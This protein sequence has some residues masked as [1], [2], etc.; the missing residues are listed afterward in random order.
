MPVFHVGGELILEDQYI[1]AKVLLSMVTF[2]AVVGCSNRS[3]RESSK[4]FFHLPAIVLHQGK[5]LMYSA[6]N[7]E[8]FGCRVFTVTI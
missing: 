8:Q 7:D 2:G 5:K 1:Q 4:K 3:S 6:R